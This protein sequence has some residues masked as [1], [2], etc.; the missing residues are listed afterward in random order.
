MNG[1]KG[2]SAAELRV[3]LA[4]DD[5][6][7]RRLVVHVLEKEG[8]RVLQARD[9][10]EALKLIQ[11]RRPDA[12]ILDAMMPGV[13]GLEVLHTIRQSEATRDIPVMMLSGRSLERDMVT[14]F[15]FGANDYLVKPFRPAELV[16]RLK[17]LLNPARRWERDER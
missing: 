17:R 16:V 14:G 15:D 3:V 10:E 1:G 9:G 11:S 13:D 7:L 8:L 4:E 2:E 6:V 12:I 5:D